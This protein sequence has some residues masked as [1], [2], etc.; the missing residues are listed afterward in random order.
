[1]DLAFTFTYLSLRCVSNEV[2]ICA[3]SI[4]IRQD[5]LGA[6]GRTVVALE[7]VEK[8]KGRI[9]RN[10]ANIAIGFLDCFK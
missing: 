7:G 8:S 2:E 3:L 4:S 6:L 5:A 1:M 9:I 10:T